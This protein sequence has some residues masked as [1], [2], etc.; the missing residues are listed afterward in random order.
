MPRLFVKGLGLQILGFGVS[1][2]DER[3]NLLQSLSPPLRFL[4][5][6]PCQQKNLDENQHLL[7]ALNQLE[8]VEWMAAHAVAIGRLDV[9]LAQVMLTVVEGVSHMVRMFQ[10]KSA[11]GDSWEDLKWRYCEWF[12][13]AISAT[14]C[15]D[16][17]K[18]IAEACLAPVDVLRILLDLHFQEASKATSG[19]RQ[20]SLLLYPADIMPAC[21]PFAAVPP[22]RPLAVLRG[23]AGHHVAHGGGIEVRH[24]LEKLAVAT[25]SE[26]PLVVVNLGAGDGACVGEL[27]DFPVT[28]DPA[29]CEFDRGAE[30]LAVEGRGASR[31]LGRWPRVKVHDSY[32]FPDNIAGIV[33]TGALK[34]IDLLKVDLDHADC[35]FVE[36]ILE[37]GIDPPLVL[38][39]EYNRIFPPP[40]RFK[41]LF[42]PGRL[43]EFQNA[44]DN[45]D[46]FKRDRHWMGC[47]LQ[48]WLDIVT[49]FN[50]KLFQMDF[51]DLVFV[52]AEQLQ[53]AGLNALGSTE[54]ELRYAWLQ[55]VHC[56]APGRRMYGL[57]AFSILDFRYLGELDAVGRCELAMRFWRWSEMGE[58]SSLHC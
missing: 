43:A 14:R 4:Y 11:Y 19:A 44:S 52:K 8:E 46:V 58:K 10:Y 50:Y 49:P 13:T 41:E 3:R 38:V 55:H 48:A 31:L 42:S 47:S 37:G 32:V 15:D 27:S 33:R 24:L 51:F 22:S 12:A 54:D 34:R 2:E 20:S 28:I 36:S 16:C 39:V 25:G 1:A 29:N 57:Q 56:L 18:N 35:F 30:G 6:A 9:A 21:K 40:L 7:R 17:P 5:S 23:P 26:E 53:L 45:Y